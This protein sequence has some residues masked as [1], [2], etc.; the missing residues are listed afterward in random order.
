MCKLCVRA[1]VRGVSVVVA[2]HTHA[3]SSSPPTQPSAPPAPTLDYLLSPYDLK[4]LNSY[5]RS[6][7]DHHLIA[8][9]IP[10]ISRLIFSGQL[11]VHLTSVQAGC[12]PLAATRTLTLA[13]TRILTLAVTRTLTYPR[14]KTIL[15]TGGDSHGRRAAVPTI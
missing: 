10:I 15:G 5:S 12:Q 13:V 11:R 14:S 1:T 7:V 9:L 6:L 2:A 3:H 4:R 8:D